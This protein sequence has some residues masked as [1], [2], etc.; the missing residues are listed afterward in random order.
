[1][2]IKNRPTI[3]PSN[4]STNNSRCQNRQSQIQNQKSLD[5]QSHLPRRSFDSA[6]GA[7]QIS[8]VQIGHLRF[9]NLFDLLSRDGAYLFFLWTARTLLEGGG[10]FEQISGRRRFGFKGKRTIRVDRDHHR[11]F[12]VRI[13]LRGLRVK[14]FAEFHDVN[15]VL[16]QR[17]TDR[18]RRIRFARRNLKF[19]IACDFLCHYSSS[20]NVTFSTS[21]KFNSTGVERPKIVTVTFSVDLSSLTS[22]TLPVK[23]WNGPD[24]M[25]TVSPAAYENFGLGFSAAAAC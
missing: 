18:R 12:E 25:R 2:Q 11:N 16:A 17:R 13:H 7:L 10:L 15:A 1:M 5:R 20:V 3:P 21:R 4:Q 19:D 22:S 9:R 14:G 24:L 6:H 8:C 23:L